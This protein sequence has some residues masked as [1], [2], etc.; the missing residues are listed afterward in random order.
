VAGVPGAFEFAAFDQ[1]HKVAR[2]S[3]I[4]DPQELLYVVIGNVA[5]FAGQSQHL[6]QLFSFAE[7][8]FFSGFGE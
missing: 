4:R 5:A 7:L 1:S 2:S 8:D 3:G 6:V